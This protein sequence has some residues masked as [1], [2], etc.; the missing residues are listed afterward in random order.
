MIVATEPGPRGGAS[1]DDTSSAKGPADLVTPFVLSSSQDV[2]G[3][4]RTAQQVAS[5]MSLEQ[6]DQVRLATALSEIGRDRLGS[7]GLEV[8]FGLVP[9]GRPAALLV[10]FA[11]TGGPPPAKETLDLAAKLVRIDHEAGAAGGRIVV[12]QPLPVEAGSTAEQRARLM[13]VLRT[14]SRS[15][16]ADDLRAQT[17]DLI[18]TLE[19]TRAQRE[20][21][22]RLNEELEETNRGVLALYSELT[23]ELEATNSGVLA[24]HSELEDKR[25]QLQEAS[26]AKTRFWTNISHELRT[27]VN[28]VVAL[29]SLLLGPGSAALTDEQREQVEFIASSGN[30]LLSLV[31]DLLDVAKAEAGHLDIQPEPVDLRLLVAHLS[32]ILLSVH[33]HDPVTLVMPRSERQP[34]LVTDETLLVRILRNLLSNALKFTERGEVRLD[35]EADPEPSAPAVLFTVTDTGIGIPPEELGRVFEVF[36][37][38]RGPH[39]NGRPGTGLGLPY[40]RTLA[41]LLGGSLTLTSTVGVGTRAEVRLPDL[42]HEY[43][44][45][46]RNRK[47]GS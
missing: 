9:P 4:R 43:T 35:I 42:G 45:E 23:Q 7:R 30:T 41:E 37:Q 6:Q 20:E 44:K 34:S 33:G 16:E 47:G 18:A 31:N 13:E 25:Q 1:H 5:A 8:F 24:L 22:R 15:T 10:T 46:P 26:E 2:F 29:S 21:L 3:L 38:V 12:V 27:P 19:E 32:G 36:Y 17:R 28:S 39:Q 14:G 40:A 11:W